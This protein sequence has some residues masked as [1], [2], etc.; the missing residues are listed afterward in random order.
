MHLNLEMSEVKVTSNVNEKSSNDPKNQASEEEDEDE[1]EKLVTDLNGVTLNVDAAKKKK[2]K[3]KKKKPTD[4]QA[5]A[6]TT[7][8]TIASGSA[9]KPSKVQTSPP[10]IPICELFTDGNYPVGEIMNHPVP[11]DMDA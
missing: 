4:G 10:T 7:T 6:T 3:K 9:S 2:K 11:R 5:T 8:T 1:D